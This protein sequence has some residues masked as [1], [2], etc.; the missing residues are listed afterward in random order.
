MSNA[1]WNTLLPQLSPLRSI[2]TVVPGTQSPS[3][4]AS[5]RNPSRVR[6]RLGHA[7]VP[8]RKYLGTRTRVRVDAIVSPGVCPGVYCLQRTSI[9]ARVRIVTPDRGSRGST[10]RTD[11]G[12]L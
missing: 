2:V 9:N 5:Q 8:C 4:Y 10:R 11:I 1:L 3:R 12:K 7:T 6:R